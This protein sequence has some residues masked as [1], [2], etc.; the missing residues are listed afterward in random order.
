MYYTLSIF[1]KRHC[2]Y[3][4]VIFRQKV[5][6]GW[7]RTGLPIKLEE[8]RRVTPKLL[9]TVP[10]EWTGVSRQKVTFACVINIY[11]FYCKHFYNYEY[12]MKYKLI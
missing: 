12:L 7:A 10:G 1:Q 6:I 2:I 4:V 8:T 11:N 9:R 5:G 3:M